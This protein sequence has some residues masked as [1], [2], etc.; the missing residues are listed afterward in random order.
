MSVSAL[1]AHLIFSTAL[2][3]WMNLPSTLNLTSDV[4]GLS[5]SFLSASAAV[6]PSVYPA[7]RATVAGRPA[8]RRSAPPHPLRVSVGHSPTDLS[9]HMTGDEAKQVKT[10]SVLSKCVRHGEVMNWPRHTPHMYTWACWRGERQRSREP[11]AVEPLPNSTEVRLASVL[12]YLSALGLSCGSVRQMA[13]GDLH[14]PGGRNS[15]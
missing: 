7:A 10:S 3:T 13:R 6:V 2:W 8:V 14:D 15:T 5:N 1:A 4:C 9:L 11:A 12:A